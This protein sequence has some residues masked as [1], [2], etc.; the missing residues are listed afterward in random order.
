MGYAYVQNCFRLPSC[1]I[2]EKRLKG[3]T[4]RQFPKQ[5]LIAA[6]LCVSSSTLLS[7]FPYIARISLYTTDYVLIITDSQYS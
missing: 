3:V 2:L 1:Q 6:G 7:K 5:S 4:D